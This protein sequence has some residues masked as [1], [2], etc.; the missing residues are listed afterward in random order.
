[1]KQAQMSEAAN[2]LVSSF[3]AYDGDKL[4][5]AA[6]SKVWKK[7]VTDSLGISKL[8][9]KR[10][11]QIL[12]I[13]KTK[14]LLIDDSGYFYIQSKENESTDDSKKPHIENKRTKETNHAPK[15]RG[16]Y[17]G[18]LLEAELREMNKLLPEGTNSTTLFCYCPHCG[19][20][21]KMIGAVEG[22]KRDKEEI[23]P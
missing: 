12:E 21:L 8:Y 10:M 1:M 11:D 7:V 18:M 19:K 17:M 5:P 6:N 13:A 9:K 15:P 20:G 14:G 2:A 3:K 22:Q 23:Y 4:T 16:Q